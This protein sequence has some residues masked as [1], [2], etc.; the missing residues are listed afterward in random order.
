MVV[1]TSALVALILD[2]PE[3][4]RFRGL[5][6]D[7]ASLK[8]STVSVLE[9]S[10][11]LE[12]RISPDAGRELDLFLTTSG[13]EIASFDEEQLRAARRAWR[14]FGK[15]KHPAGLNMGDC[16]SYALSKVTG[17][18]LLFK[19]NDFPQTDVESAL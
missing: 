10:L 7:A 15:G 16:A 3:A 11:V 2:E 17:E 5:V 8:V 14:K 1:D 19:G 6:A 13:F 18:P 9:A 4:D 12:A